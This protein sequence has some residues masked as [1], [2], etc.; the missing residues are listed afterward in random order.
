MQCSKLQST[1]CCTVLYNVFCAVQNSIIC[2]VHT[3]SVLFIS[4][5][6]RESRMIMLSKIYLFVLFKR[7]LIKISVKYCSF[8]SY[9]RRI[10]SIYVIV[11]G[12]NECEKVFAGIFILIKNKPKKFNRPCPNLIFFKIFFWNFHFILEMCPEEQK[13]FYVFHKMHSFRDSDSSRYRPLCQH[14]IL[15]WPKST[16]PEQS[17]VCRFYY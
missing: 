2:T 3:Y 6:T 12:I 8:I 14:G 5:C 11:M 16:T 17:K 7:L 15:E 13:Y 10:I 1:L 9:D 4:G